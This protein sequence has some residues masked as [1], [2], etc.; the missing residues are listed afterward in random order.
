MTKDKNAKLFILVNIKIFFYFFLGKIIYILKFILLL[1][2]FRYN[3][4]NMH[5]L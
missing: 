1:D 5:N 3:L 4:Y 2:L